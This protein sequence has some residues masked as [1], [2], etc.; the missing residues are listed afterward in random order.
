[1][2]T[3]LVPPAARR[4]STI[5]RVRVA[6]DAPASVSDEE[7]GFLLDRASAAIESY[8]GRTFGEH[9]IREDF[10]AAGIGGLVLSAIPVL[11]VLELFDWGEALASAA[12]DLEPA[13]GIIRRA[14]GRAWG[15]VSITYRA[16]Y[17]LPGSSAPTLP[18][19]VEAA[20]L[21]EISAS[22]HARG[23]D[24]LLR[25]SSTEGVGASAWATPQANGNTGLLS[26]GLLWPHRRRV[27]WV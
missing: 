13:T 3:V 15:A 25:S 12:F 8:C 23:R 17:S 26:A 21:L 19:D 22:Y 24:P 16:G 2:M 27:G 5:P 11:E 20:C 9:T 10:P 6:L 1:M 14:D 18:A 7:L 4:L